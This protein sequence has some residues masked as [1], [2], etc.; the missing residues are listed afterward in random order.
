[1]V[2]YH[3][4]LASLPWSYY[5]PD[6]A[7]L[8]SMMKLKLMEQYPAS[9]FVFLGKIFPSFDWRSIVAAYWLVGSF[10]L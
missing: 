7:A 1:M 6:L 5:F 2:A 8:E 3:A 4:S 10:F 9:C